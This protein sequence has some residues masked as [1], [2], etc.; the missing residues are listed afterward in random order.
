MSLEIY[1][2]TGPLADYVHMFWFW[3]NYYPDHPQERILPH[4]SMELTINLSD[5]PFITQY[6]EHDY[7]SHS[8]YGPMLAGVRSNFFVIDTSQPATL[9]SVYFKV[10]AG[11]AIFNLSAQ[12][13]LNTHI[14]LETLWQQKAVDL[15]HRLLEASST[16]LR[17][18]ILEAA[19]L[20]RLQTTKPQ[21]HAVKYA[22]QV[23]QQTY[24]TQSMADV[25][26]QIGL[27]QTRFIQVFREAVGLTPKKFARIHRFREALHLIAEDNPYEWVDIALRC[28]YFDQAHLINEFRTL[29]GI[30]PTTYV[31][32]D[33]E[34]LFNLPYFE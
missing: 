22:L 24:L 9:L 4:G 34:H 18:Q 19:L 23:F 28:G 32:Q 29:A 30:T 7:Q 21:H 12:E 15:Y 25:A 11:P 3:E 6:P 10:G 26:E 2:P 20:Q 17:F 14:T 8:I 31:P 5:E 33:V 27:S 1:F 16:R 13:L